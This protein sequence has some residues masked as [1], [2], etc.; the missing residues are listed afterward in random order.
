V[1]L[2]EETTTEGTNRA[3]RLARKIQKSD[4]RRKIYREES[5]RKKRLS[6]QKRLGDNSSK[7]TDRGEQDRSQKGTDRSRELRGRHKGSR[8]RK[9]QL[10]IWEGK[11]ERKHL[12]QT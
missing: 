8:K 11:T 6:V 2:E 5:S 3:A 12:T 1:K 4:Q 9:S 10:K 7:T